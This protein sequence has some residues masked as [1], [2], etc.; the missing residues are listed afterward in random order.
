M[1]DRTQAVRKTRALP[2]HRRHPRALVSPKPAPK[3][4][5]MARQAVLAGKDA[6]VGEVHICEVCGW[7]VEGE[8]PDRCPLC[9]AKREKF[10]LVT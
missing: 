6:E 1:Q 2:I 10:V 3:E 4:S 9:G 5:K 8:P 7:T